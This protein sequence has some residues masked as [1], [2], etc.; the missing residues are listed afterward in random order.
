[1][2]NKLQKNGDVM[3]VGYPVAGRGYGADMVLSHQN[4]VEKQLGA[5]PYPGTLNVVLEKPLLLKN[6]VQLD[7]KG[8]LFGV[9][10]Y[11]NEIPCLLYRFN[12]TP[13]HV[14]EVI[15][16][17][18]L[19]NTLGLKDGQGIEILVSKENLC[20]PTL[21]RFRVWELF[22]KGRLDAYYD[23]QILKS[24]LSWSTKF[25][26]KKACQSKKEFM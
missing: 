18:H 20:H 5:M 8:K 7:A 24:F 13:M 1:M 12:F 16:P 10:G 2:E 11:I 25:W 21:W 17:V 23:D 19:R 15:A 14:L 6:A 4:K 9:R 26:H 22:Y 3:I